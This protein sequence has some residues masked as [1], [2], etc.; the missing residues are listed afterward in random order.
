MAVT[1]SVPRAVYVV[2]VNV[3]AV[4]MEAIAAAI[5]QVIVTVVAWVIYA[6]V[7]GLIQAILSGITGRRVQIQPPRIPS[8][9]NVH[10][11][12]KRTSSQ[13]GRSAYAKV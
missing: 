3:M 12:Q 5:A 10:P 8:F 9:A 1:L 4:I 6:I 2:A 11:Q 7:G 13:T